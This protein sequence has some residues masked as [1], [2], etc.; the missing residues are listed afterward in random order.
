MAYYKVRYFENA[1]ESG[2]VQTVTTNSEG[3]ENMLDNPGLE[4]MDYK[5]IEIEEE[6]K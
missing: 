2:T 6:M 4:V 5:Q 3:L 1:D